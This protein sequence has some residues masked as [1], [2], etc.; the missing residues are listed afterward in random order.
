MAFT[1][2]TDTAANLDTQLSKERNITIIPFY[3][4]VDGQQYTCM[5][6]AAFDC[7]EYY[8]RIRA[9]MTVTT[10][11][12]N[13]QSFVDYFEPYLKEGNDVLFICMSSG[14]SGTFASAGI[15]RTQLLES[16][17]ERRIRLIDSLGAGLGVGLQ[18]LRAADYRDS[19]LDVDQTAD[20]L[21]GHVRRMYQVFI[22]DDLMHLRRTGRLS[23]ISAVV[24]TMLGIKPLLKGSEH[25]KIVAFEKKRGRSNAIIALADKYASYVRDIDSQRIGI[26]HTDCK[27]DALHL[28]EL[29]R[30]RGL[31]KNKEVMLVAHEPVTGSHLGPD[32]LALFFEGD[33]DVRLH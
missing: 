1:I 6:T 23:N 4:F 26:S 2:I 17:P 14:I 25:G 13:P 28:I 33:E 32:S 11:Q 15:A 27:E 22:V 19:G 16:Y 29:L 3:Y 31:P 18:A 7:K 12:V 24:G 5:D 30:E 10:S 8:N 9:G 20:L 21:E